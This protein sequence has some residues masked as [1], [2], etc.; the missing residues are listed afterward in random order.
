MLGIKRALPAGKLVEFVL[1]GL[2]L[3]LELRERAS[4]GLARRTPATTPAAVPVLPPQPSH[5]DPQGGDLLL[6]LRKG[7]EGGGGA[8]RL[9]LR[10]E[11]AGDHIGEAL[12]EICQ[13]VV[14]PAAGYHLLVL[15]EGALHQQVD[16]F[17]R[18]VAEQVERHVVGGGE[19]TF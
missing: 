18:V 9:P 11:A 2:Q 1:P 17:R 5:P 12:A 19:L 7:A 13:P 14:E 15:A 8:T 10:L 4:V 6:G 3:L 16:L